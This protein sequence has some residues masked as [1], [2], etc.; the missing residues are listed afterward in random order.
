MTT[1]KHLSTRGMVTRK[2]AT[3]RMGRRFG[4]KQRGEDLEENKEVEAEKKGNKK[5]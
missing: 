5:E 4:E 1:K 3:R 2:L